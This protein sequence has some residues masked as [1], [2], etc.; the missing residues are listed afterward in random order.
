MMLVEAGSRQ[1]RTLASAFERAI[2]STAT[3][4]VSELAEDALFERLAAFDRAYGVQ[5]GRCYL[6]LRTEERPE[7][8][9]P[10]TIQALA[11]WA[12][13]CVSGASSD[14]PGNPCVANPQLES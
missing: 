10:L 2:R 1:P 6:S 3:R 11:E 7:V 4:S 8:R 5:E 9:G 12:A 14:S 13:A